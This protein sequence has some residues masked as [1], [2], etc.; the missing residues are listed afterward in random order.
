MSTSSEIPL[1]I[2]YVEETRAYTEHVETLSRYQCRTKI[3]LNILD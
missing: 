1:K 2:N 3:H